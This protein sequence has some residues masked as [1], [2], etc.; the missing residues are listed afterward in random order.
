MFSGIVERLG[1]VTAVET[2]ADGAVR[3]TLETG[4]PDLALGE[5]VAVNGACMTIVESDMS[6]RAQV[7]VSAESLARTNLKALA[8]GG[9]VNLER[10]VTLATRLSGHLVQ[11]H[12]DGEARVASIVHE[13]GAW[14]TRFDLP[15]ALAPY[16]VEKGS[17]ALNGVSLTLNAVEPVENG[18]F[19]VGV[20]L[21]PHTWTHTNLQ[22]AAPGDPINVE[23]DV[24][25]KYVERLCHASLNA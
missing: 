21:I 5:S 25:A 22:H 3:L 24:L 17:I 20:T 23:V 4:F 14:K 18:R 13:D 6:G 10:A 19:A 7:F 9:F 16:C 11:G 12:V 1:Q 2:V 15:A 8:V